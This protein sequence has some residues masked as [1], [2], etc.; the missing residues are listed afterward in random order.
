MAKKNKKNK[1]KKKSAARSAKKKKPVKKAKAAKKKAKKA[2]K[3]AAP[4]AAPAKAKAA[5]RPKKPKPVKG[6]SK[7]EWGPMRRMLL[8]KRQATL[9]AMR[10]I[11]TFDHNTDTGDEADQA[12]RSLEKEL[13]FELSDNERNLLDQIE[14][15]LRKMEKGTYGNCEMCRNPIAKL[16]VKA[17]PFARYCIGCQNNAE[18]ATFL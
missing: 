10:K 9:E 4:K 5:P 1:A 7:A 13:Q 3:K 6:I 18:R 14:G 2:K 15:A 16:R 17:L 11:A 12:G 8:A